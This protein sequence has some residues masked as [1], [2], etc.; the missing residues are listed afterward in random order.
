VV[1]I[2]VEEEKHKKANMPLYVNTVSAKILVVVERVE[3]LKN[4]QIPL[5]VR[6]LE[7]NGKTGQK[8]YLYLW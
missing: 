2:L 6:V 3:T 5:R 4:T 1:T 7:P 8:L